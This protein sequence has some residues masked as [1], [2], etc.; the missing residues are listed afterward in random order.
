MGEGHWTRDPWP[1]LPRARGAIDQFQI[2]DAQFRITG[3]LLHPD[4][5]VNSVQVLQDGRLLGCAELSLRPDVQA[6]FPALQGHPKCGFEVHGPVDRLNAPVLNLNFLGCHDSGPAIH[7]PWSIPEDESA[8][9]E[10]PIPNSVL[11]QRV[12]GNTSSKSFTT[13]GFQGAVDILSVLHRY[14]RL[15]RS[16]TLLDWGCGSAR[17][18]AQ[19][20]RLLPDSVEIHGCDIDADAIRWCRSAVPGVTFAVSALEPPLPYAPESFD[21]VIATSVMTHLDRRRQDAWLTEIRR[22]LRD[23]G[24]FVASTHGEFAAAFSPGIPRQLRR[25]QIIDDLQD[26]ALD[27]VAPAGY[28]RGVYQTQSYTTANW[29]RHFSVREQIPAGL[30]GFQ[31]LVVLQKPALSRAIPA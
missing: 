29:S 20:S 15:G 4:I 9:R 7:L 14:Q 3:W 12:S 23:G 27:G 30:L 11:M 5:P 25:R 16:F 22:V 18:T 31:D 13:A 24:L 26:S 8:I 17:M 6:A 1:D 19:I 10:V 2:D 21:V 28:Y